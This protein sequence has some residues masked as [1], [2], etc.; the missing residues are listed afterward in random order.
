LR[1]TA[2]SAR[3]AAMATIGVNCIRPGYNRSAHHT[4]VASELI[5][6]KA[7]GKKIFMPYDE[8]PFRRSCGTAVVRWPYHLCAFAYSPGGG[9]FGGGVWGG[10]ALGTAACNTRVT[11][12]SRSSPDRPAANDGPSSSQKNSAAHHYNS[13]AATDVAKALQERGASQVV[14][15]YSLG[16]QKRSRGAL[17]R[18]ATWVAP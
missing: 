12:E 2:G 16:G 11:W 15:A 7:S 17:G 3:I 18:L 9:R 6:P 14:L 8:S 1:Q 13:P 10:W 5:I 4:T